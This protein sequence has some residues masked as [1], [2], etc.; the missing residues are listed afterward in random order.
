MSPR[1][2]RS[3]GQSIVPAR[4]SPAD[5]L[6]LACR[7]AE[8][9]RDLLALALHSPHCAAEL[10]RI[11]T[12][13]SSGVLSAADVVELSDRSRESADQAFRAWAELAQ[14]IGL[15]MN[16][17]PERRLEQS[18]ALVQ[19]SQLQPDIITRLIEAANRTL[20]RELEF[21]AAQL[22]AEVERIRSRFVEANQGLV[23]YVAQRY[24]GMGMGQA[25]IVQEGN[26]GLLRAIDKFDHRRGGRF[27]TYAIWWVRQGIRRAMANQSRTIRIPVHALGARHTLSRAA[28][29]LAVQLGRAPTDDELTAA[30]GVGQRGIENVASLVREPL[31][32]DAPRGPDSEQR[33]GDAITDPTEENAAD[34]A[35]GRERAEHLRSL[36]H[37]LNPRERAMLRMRFGLDGTD[38]C[39]LD[40]IGRQFAVTRERVRQI[41]DAALQKL[42]RQTR[43]QQLDLAS[44]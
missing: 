25:D 24:F 5:E 41:V 8:C 26:L 3:V 43:R 29:H 23:H 1:S 12:E 38:E 17:A 28:Q 27:G 40:Q 37:T 2:N 20:P 35:S 6:Q 36:L 13:L 22:E 14:R 31:S 39:T 7:L 9:R 34:H 30:T 44:F 10:R 32:L 16:G 4:I 42:Q 11:T 15:G 33:L 19:E 21:R 18:H